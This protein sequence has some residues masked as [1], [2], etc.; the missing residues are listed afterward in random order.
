MDQ[1]GDSKQLLLL[2]FGHICNKK[3]FLLWRKISFLKIF[4][5]SSD[6]SNFPIIEKKKNE[7]QQRQHRSYKSADQ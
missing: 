7:P 2:S 5:T 4:K 3:G 1:E 6:F